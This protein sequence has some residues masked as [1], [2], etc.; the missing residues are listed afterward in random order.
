MGTEK[1]W[2]NPVGGS[3]AAVLVVG[4]LLTMAAS[5]RSPHQTANR[6][7]PNL[8]PGRPRGNPFFTQV[9]YQE[10]KGTLPTVAGAEYVNDD[11]LC[12][13]CHGTYAHT[14]AQNV[15]RV[16]GC[17]GCHGP[18]SR[19]LE[20]QG[21]EPGLIFSFKSGDPV[22]RAEAC[23]R[24]HEENNCDEGA[25]WR[26]SK[27][28]NCRVT[29]VDCHRGHYNVAPGTPATTTP[30]MTADLQR[31]PPAVMATSFQVPVAGTPAGPQGYVPPKKNLPSIRGMSNHLGAIAP[32]I[33]YRCHADKRVLQE[34]A[35]P[36]QICG[37]NGFN[38]TTCHDP[39]GQLKEYGQKDLCLTCHTGADHGLA[40]LNPRAQR[41]GLHGLPQSASEVLR[42]AGREHLPYQRGAAQAHADVGP[43]AGGLLQMPS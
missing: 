8:D 23:L 38:C 17:E 42:A 25:R 24:C 35:G 5:C 7:Q 37:D 1:H 16:E 9:S 41:R 22:A 10:V 33:C 40:F 20:T 14:F 28:A 12:A 29:C 30:G 13:T 43:G 19:H 6:T 36:H 27:H 31:L 18:A 32:G 21:R 4:L 39:H 15:H 3:I 34:I 11:E 2:V 26:R